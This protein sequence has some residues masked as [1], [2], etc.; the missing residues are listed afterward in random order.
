MRKNTSLLMAYSRLLIH[1]IFLTILSDR[2]CF[3]IISKKVKK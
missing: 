1:Y 2:L 3:T